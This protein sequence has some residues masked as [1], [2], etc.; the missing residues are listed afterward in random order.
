MKK[1]GPRQSYDI[2][3]HER[4]AHVPRLPS[5]RLS[6]APELDEDGEG[7]EVRPDEIREEV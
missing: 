2:A 7:P 6:G 5:L 4:A 3:V 1:G